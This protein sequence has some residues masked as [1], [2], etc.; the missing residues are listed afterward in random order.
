MNALRNPKGATLAPEEIAEIEAKRPNDSIFLGTGDLNGFYT[1]R[2]VFWHPHYDALGVFTHYEC[3]DS[4]IQNLSTD[5]DEAERKAAEYAKRHGVENFA[6]ADFELDEWSKWR[7][8]NETMIQ[9]KMREQIIDFG[10]SHA[11]RSYSDVLETHPDYMRWMSE[12]GVENDTEE[13]IKGTRFS[14]YKA[15]TVAIKRLVELGEIVIPEKDPE[16]EIAEKE[17][18]R[19]F[20]TIGERVELDAVILFKKWIDNAFGGSSLVIMEVNGRDILKTFTTSDG[21][22]YSAK[23]DRIRIKATIDAHSVYQDKKETMIKRPK[24]VWNFDNEDANQAGNCKEPKG[25]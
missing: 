9:A 24:L 8:V 1:L 12:S 21:L 3:H 6:Y 13:E 2:R 18:S 23:G 17:A 10:K 19:H 16:P 11:G 20:G 15:G 14:R 25:K 5:P 7:A 22:V 4:Y